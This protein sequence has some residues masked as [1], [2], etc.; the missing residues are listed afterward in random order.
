MRAFAAFQAARRAKMARL[1]Q[2]LAPAKRPR[3]RPPEPAFGRPAP[4]P[5]LDTFTGSILNKQFFA[6]YFT[7]YTYRVIDIA[8]W[9]CYT[10]K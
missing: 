2:A 6:G 7:Y 9:L 8:I 1:R 5:L 10:F 4:P 3:A